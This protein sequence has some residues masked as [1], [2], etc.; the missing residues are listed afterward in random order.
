MKIRLGDLR[1][2]IRE[3]LEPNRLALYTYPDDARGRRVIKVVLYSPTEILGDVEKFKKESFLYD[4]DNTGIVKGYARFQEPEHPCN[5]AWEVTSIAGKGLGKILYGLGYSLTPNGRLMPDRHYT[6]NAGKQAWS[7][8]ATKLNGLPLDDEIG[9]L[10][11]EDPEDDCELQNPIDAGGPDP[12]LDVAY[13]GGELGGGQVAGMRAEHWS[14]VDELEEAG[15][16]QDDF[17][18]WLK[19]AGGLKFEKDFGQ[20]I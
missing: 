3:A 1:R 14:T 6:T 13:E 5:G 4:Q 12:L 11:P 16:N 10:T 15:L 9:S 19:R 8:A 2:L 17:E 20:S 18:S 7:K